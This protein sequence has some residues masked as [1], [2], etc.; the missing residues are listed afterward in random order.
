MVSSCVRSC[1]VGIA[2]IFWRIVVTN[3]VRNSGARLSSAVAEVAQV[4]GTK[5]DIKAYR[6]MNAC[7]CC[8]Y[9]R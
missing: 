1:T 5:F 8:W 4:F 9:A 6:S 2:G 3:F 7:Y